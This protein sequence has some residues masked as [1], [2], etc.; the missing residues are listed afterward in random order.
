MALANVFHMDVHQEVQHTLTS[1]G[2]GIV[3]SRLLRLRTGPGMEVPQPSLLL[4]CDLCESWRMIDPLT[5]RFQLR[6]GIRWQDIEPV[7]G[8]EL[9]AQDVVY[10][11]EQQRTPGW[12]NAPLL[13]NLQDVVAE[14]RYGLKVTLKHGFPDADFLVSLADGHTKVVAEEAVGTGDLKRGPVIGSGPWIWKSTREDI[15]SAFEK[16]PDYFEDGLPFV[17]ELV[18]RVIRSQ[19]EDRLA[20]FVVGAVDVYSP[21]AESWKRLNRR[22]DLQFNSFLSRQG[23][24]GLILAMNVSVPPFDNL[25]VRRAVLR[26]LDPWEYVRAIWGGQGYVSLGLPVLSPNWLVSRDEMRETYFADP[27]DAS[28]ILSASGLATPVRFDLTVADSGDIYLEQGRRIEEDLRSVGFAPVFRVLNPTQ[29][30]DRVWRDREYQ[31][32]CRCAPP[33]VVH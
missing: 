26:T 16:N 18:I 12:A 24:T 14:G 28:D 33:Y 6:K 10:S 20:A 30:T 19:E 2:P 31:L 7:N 11:Y 8:R 21:S 13:R 25:Q 17:D 23:G 15:G 5:Y 4:E 3:Y 22:T 32:V 1:L 29:Y 27:S 9:V